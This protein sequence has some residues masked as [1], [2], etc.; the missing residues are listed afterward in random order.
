[1][2]FKIS[3]VGIIVIESGLKLTKFS[4][5]PFLDQKIP[6]K[7]F[8]YKYK[9]K[10]VPFCREGIYGRVTLVSKIVVYKSKGLDLLV[11]HPSIKLA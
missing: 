10:R 7:R 2:G 3:C 1:M 8:F 5:G 4:D 11:E 9:A 6:A